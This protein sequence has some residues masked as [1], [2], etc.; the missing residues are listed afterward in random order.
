MFS[1]VSRKGEFKNI[2]NLLSAKISFL[3]AKI[4]FFFY[5][6]FF[7]TPCFQ[8]YVWDF[9]GKGREGGGGGKTILKQQFYLE[10]IVRFF[11]GG[12][13][14]FVCKTFLAWTFC[15]KMHTQKEKKGGASPQSS[16][17]RRTLFISI[18]YIR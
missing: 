14:R 1:G 4:C 18:I 10:T 17:F 6:L 3:L 8:A 13:S 12:G 2:K 7:S 16:Q 5:L 15:T 11:L 9:L